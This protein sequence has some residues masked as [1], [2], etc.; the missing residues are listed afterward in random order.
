MSMKTYI[1]INFGYLSS[2]GKLAFFIFM[3]GAA[4]ADYVSQNLCIDR[5]AGNSILTNVNQLKLLFPHLFI[6]DGTL[7]RDKSIQNAVLS[8]RKKFEMIFKH[9]IICKGDNCDITIRSGD[10]IDNF[11]TA[12]VVQCFSFN[13]ICHVSVINGNCDG[14][15]LNY[16]EI[17]YW[18]DGMMRITYT[19]LVKGRDGL[20]YA[21][22]AGDATA[23][24]PEMRLGENS[25]ILGRQINMGRFRSLSVL[26]IL[27]W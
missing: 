1:D 15:F 5:T 23:E 19:H 22:S 25:R 27:G 21:L 6:S 26:T 8:E 12:K 4:K 10:Y 13:K 7:S 11:R 17:I 9:Q 14:L 16:R 20:K 24:E 18:A 2:F 3:C